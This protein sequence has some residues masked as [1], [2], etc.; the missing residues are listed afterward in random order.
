MYNWACECRGV[1]Y[2]WGGCIGC[3]WS[4]AGVNVLLLNF[5][6]CGGGERTMR[7]RLHQSGY[8]QQGQQ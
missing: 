3:G 6:E 2:S 8:R 4:M 5:R 1:S 7:Q